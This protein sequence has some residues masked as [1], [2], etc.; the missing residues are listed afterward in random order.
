MKVPFHS[1]LAALL[2][3]SSAHAAL[4]GETVN[5]QRLGPT[6]STPIGDTANG[7]YLVGAGVEV[8]GAFQ[9]NLNL[10]I[11]DDQLILTF[12]NTR[13]SSVP[14]A[15]VRLTDAFGRI[16]SFNALSVDA[17]SPLSFDASRLSFDADHLWINLAGLAFQ[18]G[19]R[20]VLNVGT[21]GSIPGNTVPEPASTALLLAGLAG[22]AVGK[23]R[24]HG[25]D[26]AHE[27][28]ASV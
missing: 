17:S 12:G 8:Q 15:G 21:E 6:I 25:S 1:A 9:N 20:L 13:L 7:D 19:N 14:F 26:G 2:V 22:L 27:G 5:F 28:A 16:D 18:A 10:D 3:T 24:R 23:R 11:T 4:L